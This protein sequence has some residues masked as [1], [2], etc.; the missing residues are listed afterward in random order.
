MRR[1]SASDGSSRAVRHENVANNALE[2]LRMRTTA[3]EQPRV[4]CGVRF[5]TQKQKQEKY[6][7]EDET[8]ES[9]S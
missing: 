6:F 5:Q 4:P 3:A 2:R 9:P 7:K 8:I 1:W